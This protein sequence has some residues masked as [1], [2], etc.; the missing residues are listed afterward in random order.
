MIRKLLYMAAVTLALA[1][2]KDE[3]TLTTLSDTPR[4]VVYCMPTVGDTTYIGVSR[5]IPIKAYNDSV[6][7]TVVSDARI[8]YSV[9]GRQLQAEPMGKG[10]YRVVGRQQA[11]DRVSLSVEAD[12][13]AP[14]SASTV[15]PDTVA[16]GNL[17]VAENIPV[18]IPDEG[19]SRRFDQVMATFTDDPATRCYYAVRVRVKHYRGSATGY[20]DGGHSIYYFY[21]YADYVQKRDQLSR[22]SAR[23]EF[24]DSIYTY[25]EVNTQSEPL[26]MP[27][28]E[29]DDN[30][31]F[32]NSFYGNLYIFD[33]AT[34]NG[35]TYTLHLNVNP[36][37]SASYHDPETGYVYSYDFARA[38]QVE[39]LRITPEYYRFMRSLNELDNNEMARSGLSQIRPMQS[40]VMGGLGLV[41]GW[42]TGRTGWVLKRS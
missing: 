35:A 13:M 15:I 33:D 34:I 26:L 40:N 14:V 41:G 6:K 18:Y 23:V 4:L 39:L 7:V 2:C 1:S 37:S 5:S 20:T 9:D 28:T 22:D 25:P 36:S 27:P 29:I 32:S 10:F 8:S 19:Q 38:Y 24:R 3:V 16:V 17:Q 42:N 21:D 12:G 31:G 30:F 11:G